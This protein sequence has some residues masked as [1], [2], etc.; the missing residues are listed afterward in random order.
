[1][2]LQLE[3]FNHWQSWALVGISCLG[4]FGSVIN[5]FVGR[6]IANKITGNDLKHLTDNFQEIKIEHKELKV[7]LKKDLQ[8]IFRRLGKIERNQSVR[9]ALCNERHSIKGK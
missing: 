9:D 8:K 1:M 5:F 7:D 3:L 6:H 4:V 2:K